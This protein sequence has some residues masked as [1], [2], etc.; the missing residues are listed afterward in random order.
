M[1]LAI[2]FIDY[3]CPPS[4][5][6]SLGQSTHSLALLCRAAGWRE[7]GRRE[8]GGGEEGTEKGEGEGGREE[9]KGGRREGG[10]GTFAAWWVCWGGCRPVVPPHVEGDNIEHQSIA[11]WQ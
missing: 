9:G 4:C 7:G 2:I 8:G 3:S 10:G 11:Q 1:V 6:S 5:H